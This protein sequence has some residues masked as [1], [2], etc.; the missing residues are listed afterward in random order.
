MAITAFTTLA[1]LGSLLGLAF[2]LC[3]HKEKPLTY[4][5]L[6]VSFFVQS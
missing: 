2:Q 1:A 5:L 4:A 3:K 6:A